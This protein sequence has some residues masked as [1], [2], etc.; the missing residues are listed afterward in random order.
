MEHDPTGVAVASF[1]L[2][3]HV[4]EICNDLPRGGSSSDKLIALL[5]EIAKGETAVLPS[6]AELRMD[7]PN[8]DD[9]EGVTRD[10]QADH[11]YVAN[12][13]VNRLSGG[14]NFK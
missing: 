8:S 13:I 9:T 5:T 12:L 10:N 1:F 2:G 7:H 6:G 14:E 4:A 11:Q 3:V